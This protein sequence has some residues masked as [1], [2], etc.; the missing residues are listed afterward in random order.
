M[1]SSI[2]KCFYVDNLLQSLPTPEAARQMVDTL[3]E[4]LASG[5]V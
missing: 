3:R 5:G 2:E 1:R 4:L